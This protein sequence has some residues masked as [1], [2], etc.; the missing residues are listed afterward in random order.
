MEVNK[1][2]WEIIQNFLSGIPGRS[3]SH[4]RPGVA[5]KWCPISNNL[6]RTVARVTVGTFVGTSTTFRD[7]MP[8]PATPA[9]KLKS[10]I[11]SV[12]IGV[13]ELPDSKITA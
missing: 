4:S 12:H 6:C 5:L 3:F 11:L 8:Q 9:V 7:N 10:F 2:A 1:G 13:I